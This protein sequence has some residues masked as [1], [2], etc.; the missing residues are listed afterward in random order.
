MRGSKT[1][2]IDGVEHQVVICDITADSHPAFT[3]EKR[4]VD[5]AGRVEK[6]QSK[7]R[8][9]RLLGGTMGLHRGTQVLLDNTARHPAWRQE[10]MVP[11]L[12]DLSVSTFHR[13]RGKCLFLFI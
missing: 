1:E 10:C 5:T 11:P 12:H 3:G 2:T 8:R 13:S 9:R 4:F 6:F 7:F